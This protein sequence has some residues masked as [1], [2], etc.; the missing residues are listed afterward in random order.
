MVDGGQ[1]FFKICITI[2]PPNCDPSW[3]KGLDEE[4]FEELKL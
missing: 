1:G 4:A 3:D 2:I